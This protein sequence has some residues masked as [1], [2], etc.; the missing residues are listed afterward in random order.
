MNTDLWWLD[1]IANEQFFIL[2]LSQLQPCFPTDLPLLL[3]KYVSQS[4]DAVDTVK[5]QL[6][7]FI[8][9]FFQ[10]IKN[11]KEQQSEQKVITAAAKTEEVGNSTVKLKLM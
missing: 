3:H 6:L 4:T 10:N 11:G 1:K 2:M 7:A 9:L 5:I 8:L